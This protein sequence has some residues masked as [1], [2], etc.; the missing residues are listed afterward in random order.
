MWSRLMAFIQSLGFVTQS[1]HFFSGAAATLAAALW[2]PPLWAGAAFL[3]LWCIPKE[4]LFDAMPWGENH[5]SPDWIDLLFYTLGTSLA[6]GVLF[7]RQ[8]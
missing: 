1:A 7:L 3:A 8:A 5:G 2:L 4:L 6:V